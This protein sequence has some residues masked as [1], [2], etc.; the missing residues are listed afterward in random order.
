MVVHIC[1]AIPTCG[2]VTAS[3]AAYTIVAAMAI[4]VLATEIVVPT[5]EIVVAAMEI[6]VAAMEIL[7]AAIVAATN[8]PHRNIHGHYRNSCCTH[9]NGSWC[10]SHHHLV[11]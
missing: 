10:L 5:M 11:D 7:A 3:I 2:M 4:V 6:V 9:C 8:P 1:A